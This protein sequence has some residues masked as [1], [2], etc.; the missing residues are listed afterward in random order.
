MPTLNAYLIY[1]A[2]VLDTA[3]STG[4]YYG[5][6][7]DSLSRATSLN[8]ILDMST[9]RERQKVLKYHLVC[10]CLPMHVSSS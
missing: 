4:N 10:L 7:G 5:S 6:T 2:L 9:T 1:C 8:N 3:S